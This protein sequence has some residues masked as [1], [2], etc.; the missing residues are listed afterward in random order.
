MYSGKKC[1]CKQKK[2]IIY[3]KFISLVNHDFAILIPFMIFLVYFMTFPIYFPLKW[4]WSSMSLLITKSVEAVKQNLSSMVSGMFVLLRLLV[5]KL[6]NNQRFKDL[7]NVLS[8]NCVISTVNLICIV[9]KE[10]NKTGRYTGRYFS[11]VLDYNNK[12]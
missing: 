11:S 1:I 4:F 8:R 2:K 3:I 6:K 7:K 12:Q 10:R 9:L 5:W